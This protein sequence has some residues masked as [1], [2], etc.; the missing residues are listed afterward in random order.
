MDLIQQKFQYTS[1]CRI[2]KA[3]LISDTKALQAGTFLTYQKKADGWDRNLYGTLGLVQQQYYGQTER[4]FIFH[5]SIFQWELDSRIMSLVYLDFVP[6]TYIQTMSLIYQQRLSNYFSSEAGVLAV[7][8]IE[9]QRQ[10]NLLEKL[11]PSPYKEGHLKFDYRANRSSTLTLTGSSGERSSDQLKRMDISLGYRV[12]NFFSKNWDTQFK[13]TSRKNFT[14]T[15]SIVAWSLGYFSKN[16]E[17]TLDA[18][19]GIQNNNDRPV[20][21]P[22]NAEVSL[23]SFFSRQLFATAALQRSADETVTILGAFLKIGYRFGN[24]EL[25]PIRDGAAPRGS[26]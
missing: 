2:D 12:Q 15:D 11:D 19:Y 21:H 9:Y 22:Q 16:Y 10:Q 24:Q 23:T 7:D 14:S 6:K 20:T 25:P 1:L 8:V 26:L 18:D 3:Y 13:I 17:V 4:Q 5:N